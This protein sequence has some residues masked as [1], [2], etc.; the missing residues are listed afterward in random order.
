MKE[1]ANKEIS[2]QLQKQIE[3]KDWELLSD[4]LNKDP[5]IDQLANQYLKPF[6]VE[7]Y[8]KWG[9]KITYNINS[10]KKALFIYAKNLF[11]VTNDGYAPK[12]N[13]A[14]FQKLKEM[15]IK[16]IKTLTQKEVRM[17]LEDNCRGIVYSL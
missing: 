6:R 8:G 9:P 2:E 3:D 15:S 5:E 11:T 13:D 14:D 7:P 1:D 12:N 4:K 16:K 17:I 10:Q